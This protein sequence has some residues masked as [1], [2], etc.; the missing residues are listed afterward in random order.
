MC[1]SSICRRT[2]AS[3]MSAVFSSWV[4]RAPGEPGKPIPVVVAAAE[5]GGIRAAYWTSMVLH[6]L[7]DIP[8]AGRDV[9]AA[10]V[11]DQQRV[12]RQFRRRGLR[13]T[14][15]RSRRAAA[16]RANRVGDP[17]GA[18]PRADGREARWPAIS[19]SGSCRCRSAASIDRARWRRRLPRPT[20]STCITTRWSRSSPSSVRAM[21]M[22]CRCCCST[23]PACSWAAASSPVRIRGRCRTSASKSRTRST[24]T[25]SPAVTS[26]SRP[27][28]TTPRAFRTS[29][30]PAACARRTARTSGTWSTAA[31]SKTPAPTR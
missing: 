11:C 30:P 12:G 17:A 15:P 21:P 8:D 23:A 7:A 24:F 9:S 29:A 18:L 19:C 2:L 27:R 28:S 22:M 6:H 10:P 25:S 14:A 13:R 1:G 20:T 26:A 3:D 4:T 31:T 16:A 5:G